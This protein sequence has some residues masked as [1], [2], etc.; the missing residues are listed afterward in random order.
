MINFSNG[1]IQARFQSYL[2]IFLVCFSLSTTIKKSFAQLNTPKLYYT[3]DGTNPLSDSVGNGNLNPNYYSSYY[4]IGLNLANKGVGKYLST[5]ANSTI[6]KGGDFTP[7]DALT[8]EFLLRPGIQFDNQNILWSQNGCFSIR[9]G[10]AFIEFNTTAYTSSNVSVYDQFKID[11]NEIGRKSYGY[12]ID[13]EWHHIVFKYSASTG[14]KQVWVD[15]QKPSGFQKTL[16]NGLQMKAGQ[17]NSLYINNNNSFLVYKGDI[18]ELA[19][20]EYDLH[21]NVVYNHYLNFKNNQHYSYLH[22]AVNPPSP[23]PV[24]AGIDVEE[25]ATGHPNVSVDVIEQ[26]KTFPGARFKPNHSLLPNGTLVNYAFL[27][28]YYYQG[29]STAQAVKRSVDIQSILFKN[30]NFPIQV[31]GATTEWAQ[32]GDTNKFSGAWI[33]LAND[34]PTI[35]TTISTAWPHVIPQMA[36]FSSHE[37]YTTCQCLPAN[38][39]LRNSSGQF[40]N[41]LGNVTTSK[42]LSPVT[43]LDSIYLDGRTQRFYFDKLFKKLNRPLNY[44]LDESENL[45]FFNT[46]HAGL[47][48]DPNVVANKNAS[49]LDWNTY[50]GNKHARLVKAYRDTFM[51]MPELA[52]TRYQLYETEGHDFYR[53]KYT[54]SRHNQTHINGNNY[55]LASMYTRWPSNWRYNISA[56]NGWQWFV[57]SRMNEIAAGDAY[58]APA[59]GAGWDLNE[60]LNVRPGQWLGLCKAY[61]MAGAEFFYPSY[62]VLNVGT[63]QIQNPKDYAWQMIVPSLAQAVTTRYEDLFRNGYLLEGDVPMVAS[64][65]NGAK[66]FSFKAGDQRKLVV[67]RKSKTSAKYAITGTL[68]PNSNMIGATELE[69]VAQITL[70]GQPLKFSVRRQGSTYYYDKTVTPHVFYMLDGWHEYK[71]PNKWSKDFDFEAELHD[72]TLNGA[73]KTDV[74]NGTLQGDYSNFTSYLTFNANNVQARYNFTVRAL[75]ATT[76]YFWVRAR[77]LSGSGQ[78]DVQMDNGTTSAIKCISDTNWTWYRIHSNSGLPIMFNNLSLDNHQLKLTCSNT[79][80][81][82]KI[83]LSTTSGAILGNAVTSCA[84]L[85]ATISI[86]GNT[87]FCNGDSVILTA[88][89]SMSSYSWSNGASTQSIVVKSAGNYSV[90]ITSYSGTTATSTA[91]TVNVNTLPNANVNA[92]LTSICPPNTTELSVN[93]GIAYLWSTGATT[94][95]ITVSTIGSYTATVTNSLGCTRSSSPFNIGLGSCGTVAQI[96]PNGPTTFCAGGN[97]VL[98][99]NS[100]NSYLWSTGITTQSIYVNQSGTYT[101]SV[102]NNFGITSSASIVI[103][104]N[105]V[106]QV[107]I[108]SSGGDSVCEGYPLLLT[109]QGVGS[110]LWS[111]G[112]TTA[113]VVEEYAGNYTVTVTNEFG[114]TTTASYVIVDGNCVPDATVSFLGNPV[115]CEGD[116]CVFEAQPGMLQYL[117]SNGA[118]TQT[119]II[120]E[121]I[122][123]LIVTVT[124]I[125]GYSTASFPIETIM[126][127]APQAGILSNRDSLCAGQTAI[128]SN[129]AAAN[130]F[131]WS[132]GANTPTIQVT[133]AGTYL[134]TVTGSNGCTRMSSPFI[135]KSG[136]CGIPP[137]ANISASGSLTFCLGDSVTLTSASAASY[138]WSTGTT[139]KSIKIFNTGNYTVT[140]TNAVGLSASASVSVL[141]NNLPVASITSNA[142]DTICGNASIQLTATGGL[143]FLW[144]NGSTQSAC[145]AATVG[146]YIVTVTNGNGCKNSNSF[147]VK[148]GICAAPDSTLNISGTVSICEGNYVSLIAKPGQ[149]YLWSTGQTTQQINVYYAGTYTVTVTNWF[150]VSATSAPVVVVQN[151]TPKSLITAS[152]IMSICNGSTVTLTVS[153]SKSYLWSSGQTTRSIVVSQPGIYFVTVSNNKGCTSISNPAIVT[154]GNCNQTCPAPYNLA[155]TN[156]TSNVARLNWDENFIADSMQYFLFNTN[157]NLLNSNTVSGTL[158]FTTVFNLV[159]NTQ[160]KWWLKGKCGNVFSIESDTL[161]FTTWPVY[162]SSRLISDMMSLQLF[163]NPVTNS[164]LLKSTIERDEIVTVIIFNSIGKVVYFRDFKMRDTSNT[165]EIPFENEATGIYHLQFISKSETLLRKFHKQK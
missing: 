32:F 66:G 144:N 20:Y 87:T 113:S 137:I 19:V 28:G 9:M 22:S 59:V 43:P 125:N 55:A 11:L 131:N 36:G 76:Y 64:N 164:I 58:C 49:G 82:D 165:I 41:E 111:N 8:I 104:V 38:S 98:Q 56:W 14:V 12:Y 118:T 103:S 110:F 156:I 29:T 159:P 116:S 21:Q 25:F 88:N 158:D 141:V 157:S 128:L 48:M 127:S 47:S 40:I 51:S 17:F 84:S 107:Q 129:V 73:I 16:A 10:Y 37:T 15:G 52:N 96:T 117:W 85:T 121:S 78:I 46:S 115:F 72:N 81:I 3:F 33:K 101:V 136:N 146:N 154:T 142:G 92:T 147:L 93:S 50:F 63:L 79:I 161:L 138:L 23:L 91:V 42:V 68:Q 83:R 130:S 132:T 34:N 27:G 97:V 148:N 140:V 109:A 106:P 160:Y 102:T 134:V 31:A 151:V 122:S 62:F 24:T 162:G 54:E 61:A 70:D 133:A 7:T 126:K 75:T 124:N 99:C 13:E 69:G 100:Q 5:Y 119:I 90:S 39:Y 67:I 150:G 153:D 1:H 6:I 45:K 108:I 143:S 155:T 95:K 65:P 123:A 89:N 74:P 163:P 35:P 152:G 135:V 71:H 57:E 44:I 149:N 4:T 26:F 53:A 18:D 30:Y 145:T 105:P 60:E 139:T 112:E 2:F 94:K 77:V 86:N 80:Q 114:C 120:K